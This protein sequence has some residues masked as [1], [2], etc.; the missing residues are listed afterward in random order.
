[1][2]QDL[3]VR[4]SELAPA[5]QAA[6][7]PRSGSVALGLLLGVA[8]AL[9]LWGFCSGACCGRRWRAPRQPQRDTP[10]PDRRIPGYAVPLAARPPVP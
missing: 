2:A 10:S 8:A 4:L 7:S 1:M 3:V 6:P 9:W 5:V